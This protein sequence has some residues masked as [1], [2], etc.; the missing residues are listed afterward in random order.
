[1]SETA[2][3]AI[4]KTATTAAALADQDFVLEYTAILCIFHTNFLLDRNV[5]QE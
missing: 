5:F 3:T 2:N 4:T 1:M